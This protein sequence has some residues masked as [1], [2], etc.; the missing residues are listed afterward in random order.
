MA[1]H[2]GVLLAG[3]AADP[4]V[5]LSGLAVL[6]AGEREQLL[7]G[8]NDTAA[9]V[10]DA[11][12]VHE[13]VAGRAGVCPDAVAVVSGDGCLTYRG[14]MERA[15]RLA[16]YL[17]ER[18]A[19]PESVVGL[20]LGRGADMG[21]AMLAA[22]LAGGA[23]L[24]LDPG[25][26]A[27]RLAFMLA[28]SRASMLVSDRAGQLAGLEVPAGVGVVRLDDP[29]VR[30][31]IAAAGPPAPVVRVAAG[32]LAYVIYTSGSTG[33]PKGVQVAHGSV[34]DLVAGLGPVLGAGPGCRVLQFSSFSFDAAVL[35]VA[36]ALAG[37]GVL[38]VAGGA[39]RAEPGRL[40][41]LVAAAGVQVASITPSLLAVLRPG[42]LAGLGT[43]VAIGE[44]LDGGVAAAGGAGRRLLNG[45]G[46]T[47]T[48]VL[49]C[50]GV[51]GAGAGL[52]QPI[53][54][55]MANT[56]AYVLDRCLGP[57]PAGVAGE[58]FIGG[59]G[60]ARGDGYRPALRA[61]RF[62]ADGCGG[63]GGRLYRTGDL[64]RWRADG[65]VEYLGRIDQQ[66]KVR[67][68]R[69]EPGEVEAG[70]AGHPAVAA[71]AVAVT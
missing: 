44:R 15:G 21:T 52:V 22:W 28:D 32:Q 5:P 70:L 1:G 26:P 47:E 29:G 2:L 61:E 12:G 64:V 6:T 7:A 48:T 4:A 39:E 56:R 55:P 20:C 25:Y 49:C 43:L 3:V 53:G 19:G 51:A 17:R 46:P 9:P 60:V 36:P 50:T 35:E 14:L 62:V 31:R 41:A 30:A 13:L 67:G 10:P 38:V 11:G 63:G 65:Q 33:T 66:V 18:G 23:Y 45:Y 42:E 34:V 71:G 58:L 59:G 37:G 16:G 68:F 24:P 69:V 40:A 27:A 54:P 8:W 57:V